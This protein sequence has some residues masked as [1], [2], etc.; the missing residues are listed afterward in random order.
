MNAAQTPSVA[1]RARRIDTGGAPVVGL[2][3]LRDD[4]VFVLGEE[5]LLVATPGREPA[6][7]AVHAGGILASACDGERVLTGGDDGTVAAT[8]RDMKPT[9]VA[10]DAKR[11]WVDHLAP[12]PDG[13]V[14]WSAGKDVFVETRK[15]EQRHREAA[16][17]VGG[18][19]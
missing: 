11:R 17:T 3:Y 16:S 9:V 15:G 2:H 10:T 14:A 6:R 1:E 8:G 12:G 7:V 18:L 4:A 13:A 19:A 5:A